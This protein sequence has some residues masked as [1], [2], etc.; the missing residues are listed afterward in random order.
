MFMGSFV[1]VRCKNILRAN[2]ECDLFADIICQLRCFLRWQNHSVVLTIFKEQLTALFNNCCINKVHL[3]RT[4]KTGYKKI[5]W[6][7]IK[8]LR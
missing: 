6:S 3:R 7:V 1:F 2:T 8:I 5:V 4:D